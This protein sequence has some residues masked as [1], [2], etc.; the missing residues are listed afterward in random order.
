MIGQVSE[1]ISQVESAPFERAG[2]ALSSLLLLFERSARPLEAPR[3]QEDHL[4]GAL[5]TIVLDPGQQAEAAVALCHAAAVRGNPAIMASAISAVSGGTPAAVLP[6]LLHFALENWT[7]FDDDARVHFCI[8]IGRHLLPRD[9]VGHPEPAVLACF[10]QFDPR[11]MIRQTPL[12]PQH[13]QFKAAEQA[14]HQLDE[15]MAG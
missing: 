4:A 14:L 7:Q 3:A 10:R 8:I 5:S 2:A 1:I 11:Q 6:P 13:R 9:P 15:Y 12:S